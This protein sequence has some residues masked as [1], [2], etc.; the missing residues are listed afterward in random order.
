MV[1]TYQLPAAAAVAQPVDIA[2]PVPKYVSDSLVAYGTATGPGAGV[3][4]ATLA[5]PGAGEYEIQVTP[6]YGA[7]AGPMDNMQLQIGATVVGKLIV[8]AAVNGAPVVHRFPRLAVPAATAITVN[9]VGADA[10]GVYRA[11]IVATP[12]R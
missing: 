12:V 4:I 8:Q 9:Q 7:T 10:A 6:G 2:Q 3:A 11:Q 5:A 1:A